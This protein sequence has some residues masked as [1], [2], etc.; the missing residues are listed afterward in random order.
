[1]SPHVSYLVRAPEAT[2]LTLG[3]ARSGRQP[4]EDLGR[5]A[6]ARTVA[7]LVQRA[8]RE[9]GVTQASDVHLVQ[10]KCPTLSATEIRDASERS[11]QLVTTDPARSAA[12]SRGAAAL[13]VA[14]ALGEVDAAAIKDATVLRDWDIYTQVGCISSEIGTDWHEVLVLGRGA[15]GARYRMAHGGL[16]DALDAEGARRVLAQ[17]GIGDGYRFAALL[18]KCEP[19]LRGSVRGWRHTMLTDAD[20]GAFRHARATVAAVLASVCGDPGIYVSGGA[21]HQGPL[22]GGTLTV[23]ADRL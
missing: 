22:G 13:G 15:F 23:I 14:L 10:V 5:M 2:G 19:D 9:A 11:V 7:E 8:R 18:A 12:Y 20:I 6:Q 21:E 16:V 4:A 1:M 3:L 17:A